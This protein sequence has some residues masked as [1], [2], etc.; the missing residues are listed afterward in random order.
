M[1]WRYKGKGKT[2][3]G[4]GEVQL[5]SVCD[6]V[7]GHGIESENRVNCFKGEIDKYLSL[8]GIRDWFKFE[9]SFVGLSGSLTS[10]VRFI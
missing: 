2:E 6:V 7:I 9:G 1:F 10:F 8:R 5:Q 3:R 4:E